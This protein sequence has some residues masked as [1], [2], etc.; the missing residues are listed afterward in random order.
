[1]KPIYCTN[2]GSLV[3]GNRY[4]CSKCGYLAREEE[5][6]NSKIYKERFKK[7]KRSKRGISFPIAVGIIIVCALL[8]IWGA[9][10][11]ILFIAK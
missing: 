6:K 8:F 7:V 11:M 9:T 4:T 5:L 10:E 1:M 3:D 2:C